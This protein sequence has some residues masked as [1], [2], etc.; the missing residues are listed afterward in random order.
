MSDAPKEIVYVSFD[1]GEYV[2]YVCW[3]SEGKP[4]KLG[5]LHGDEEL[6]DFLRWLDSYK[7]QIKTVIIES[8]RVFGHKLKAHA[9]KSIKTEQVI[10]HLKAW[11][12][13]NRYRV[14]LQPSS[15]LAVAQKWSGVVVS[16]SNRSLRDWQSAYNHG[17]YFLHQQG[18]IK[19]RVLD[20][21]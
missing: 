13:L 21:N 4:V 6:D 14:V 8:Y 16:K 7:S 5:S 3:S 9:N 17:Y 12:R 1:P 2:G 19:A 11:G 10:G 15:I 18:V 20:D